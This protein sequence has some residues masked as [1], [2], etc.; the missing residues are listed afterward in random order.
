VIVAAPAVVGYRFGIAKE[1]V[2]SS[3]AVKMIVAAPARGQLPANPG[4]AKIIARRVRVA[5]DEVSIVRPDDVV[6]F[7]R[8][9]LYPADKVC[10][11]PS[12]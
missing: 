3:G 4:D 8:I 7:A 2:A 11:G 9:G 1:P 10:H 5:E 12:P 6:V